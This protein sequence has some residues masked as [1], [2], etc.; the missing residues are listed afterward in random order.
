MAER[1]DIVNPNHNVPLSQEIK[2]C[3]ILL[4]ALNFI[5]ATPTAQKN[6]DQSGEKCRPNLSRQRF[7]S[8]YE[9]D[10]PLLSDQISCTEK[11][12]KGVQATEQTPIDTC[13]L[14]IVTDTPCSSDT[15]TTAPKNMGKVEKE[16]TEAEAFRLRKRIEDESER[17]R[18]AN[19]A[20]DV[21]LQRL[22]LGET[23]PKNVVDVQKERIT[24]DALGLRKRLEEEAERKRQGDAEKDALLKNQSTRNQEGVE[25]LCKF[26]QQGG[27]IESNL[28]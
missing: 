11:T 16:K 10:E 21:L 8:G 18:K 22:G 15:Q 26:W 3:V 4:S 1:I 17:K 24:A 6:N 12:E 28:D 2:T 19:E 25:P 7:D 27:I 13:V 5:M 9:E 14:P 23:A 20:R